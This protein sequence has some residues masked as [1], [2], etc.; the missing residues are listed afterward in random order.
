MACSKYECV[1]GK[2]TM[3]ERETLVLCS[4]LFP[5]LWAAPHAA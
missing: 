5:R 2:R 3:G 1:E 4:P